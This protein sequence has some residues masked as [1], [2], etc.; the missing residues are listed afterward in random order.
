MLFRPAVLF[1]LVLA[2]G[3]RTPS[4]RPSVAPRADVPSNAVTPAIGGLLVGG[5]RVPVPVRV[6]LPTDPGG[7]DGSLERCFFAESRV[8]PAAPTP[9]CNVPRRYGERGTD[10][11]RPTDAA[12]VRVRG[13]DAELLAARIDQVVLHYDVAVTSTRCFEVLHDERG[14]SCHFL[15]DADGTLYQTLDLSHRARHATTVN[16]RSIGIEIAHVGAYENESPFKGLY[17]PGP[18]GLMLSIPAALH[19][20]AGGPFP[21]QTPTFLRGQVHGRTYVQPDFTRAQHETLGKLLPALARVFPLLIADRPLDL[22]RDVSGAVRMTALSAAELK[23]YRGLLGHF[24]V[25][26][27][28]IDPGPAIESLARTIRGASA[29]ALSRSS[30]KRTAGSPSSRPRA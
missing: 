10:G 18:A 7:F 9:D 21:L 29:R 28:K 30:A 13:F 1:A 23:S 22:P 4:A 6:V 20:P 26:S 17:R 24:H 15:L 19:P 16:D 8:L 14:L 12:A 2:V 5:T 27:S 3:C 11:M 25:T